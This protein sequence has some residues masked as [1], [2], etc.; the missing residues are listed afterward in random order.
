MQEQS[1]SWNSPKPNKNVCYDMII[2]SRDALVHSVLCFIVLVV[3]FAKAKQNLDVLCISARVCLSL[4]C[5]D[6]DDDSDNDD[7]AA[8]SGGTAAG[9]SAAAIRPVQPYKTIV[10]RYSATR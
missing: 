10:C 3:Y 1:S 2:G 9:G 5:S 4:C 7:D 8:G 6:V